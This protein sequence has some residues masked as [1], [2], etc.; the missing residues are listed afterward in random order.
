[1]GQR[2]R[3]E[4][5]ARLHGL[6]FDEAIADGE[7]DAEFVAGEAEAAIGGR[8]MPLKARR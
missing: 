1:L 5:A 2:Q 6:R 8:V 4:E 3:S 7:L